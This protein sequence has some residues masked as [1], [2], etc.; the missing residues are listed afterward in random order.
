MRHEQSILSIP[1]TKGT[2]TNNSESEFHDFEFHD[3]EFMHLI[4]KDFGEDH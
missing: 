2:E 1:C 4:E 3:F